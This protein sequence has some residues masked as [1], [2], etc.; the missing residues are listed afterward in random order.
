MSR[1]IVN[2][3]DFGLHPS[4]NEAI[5]KC[6]TNGIVTSTSLLAS[7]NAFNDA[8][9]LAQS[10]PN[11]GIGVHVALVGGIRPVSNPKDVPSLLTKDGVFPET[12]TELMKRIYL[13]KI[14]YAELRQ[15][16]KAQFNKIVESGLRITHA[17]GHQHMH[18]LPTVLP[19]VMECM[20]EH[21]ITRMRTPEERLSFLNGIYNP[22]R[23][24][25]KAGLSTVAA[26][27]FTIARNNGIE[28]TRYF[29]G[30]VNG[31]QLNESSLFQILKQVNNKQASHEIMTHPGMSNA[32]LGRKYHW[33]YQWE[34]EMAAM[35]SNRIHLFIKQHNIELINYGDL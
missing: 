28:C 9:S 3:D 13:G 11:L 29:W 8:V 16:I 32:I 1:L 26:K 12:Y 22:V 18:V 30:M 17:D 2:A 25:G 4:V 20:R 33:N 21:H 23:I 10:L 34:Q 35:C 5:V 31:G 24:V 19:I 14:N 7:G 15:E 27:A 6:H